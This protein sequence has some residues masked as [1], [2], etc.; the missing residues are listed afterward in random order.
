MLDKH[1]A[2]TEERAFPV[3]VGHAAANMQGMSLRDYFAA[4]NLTGMVG[5]KAYNDT[6]YTDVAD[7]CY[8]QAD[9]MMEARK[10]FG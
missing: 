2:T 4:A 1:K 10:T 7:V 9:A 6:L 5:N 3:L 8:R